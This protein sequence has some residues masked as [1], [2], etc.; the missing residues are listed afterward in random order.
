M[1][2]TLIT[3]IL[4]GFVLLIQ[5]QTW[6]ARVERI[7]GSNRIKTITIKPGTDVTVSSQI[8]KNDTFQEN[9]FYTGIF[10][11]GTKDSLYLELNSVMTNKEYVNGIKE[12]RNFPRKQYLSIMG[13][14][15]S[16]MCIPLQQIH[17]LDYQKKNISGWAELGEPII[18]TSLLVMVAAPLISIN[19]KDGS[20]NDERYK[21]W[22]LGSTAGLAAGFV[23]IFTFAILGDH[24]KIQFKPGWPDK[25]AKAWQFK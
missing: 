12:T 3:L 22:A 6:K 13:Q 21:K 23:T 10:K 25:K 9:H 16:R 24:H 19:Y 2:K 7:Q 1:K 20:F 14:D 18:L 5:A 15:T 17:A 4:A 8:F 11:G